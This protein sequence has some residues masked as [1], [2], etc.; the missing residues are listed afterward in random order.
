[1]TIIL[2]L[3]TVLV[4]LAMMLAEMRIVIL[5]LG[6][7]ILALLSSIGFGI[8]AAVAVYDV[9]SSGTVFM[10]TVHQVFLNPFFLLT[11]AY[12]GVYVVYLLL[13]QAWLELRLVLSKL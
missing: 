9:I 12:L 5:R 3:G 2:V 8:V 13:R 7:D 10:T 11:G 6:Y 4:P 1:M